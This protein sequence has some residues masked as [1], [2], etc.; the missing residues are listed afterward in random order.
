MPRRMYSERP[1]SPSETNG[2]CPFRKD[3]EPGEFPLERYEG[4]RCTIG[5]PGAEA[6]LGAPIFACHKTGEG[7]EIACAGWLATQ[8]WNHLTIRLAVADGRIPMSAMEP[9]DDWPELYKDYDEMV[10]NQAREP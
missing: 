10:E 3:A 2:A 5:A 4:L 7:R 6:Q 1:C 9:G 8:G